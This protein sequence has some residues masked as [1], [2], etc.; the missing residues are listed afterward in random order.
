M[1]NLHPNSTQ[2]P[3][4]ILDQW[5]PHLS[6]SELRVVLYVCRRTYGFGKLEDRI[7]LKQMSEGIKRKDGSVLDQGAGLS[8]SA[9]AEACKSLEQKRVL[10][11]SQQSAEGKGDTATAY[12]LNL[13]RRPGGGGREG[14]QKSDTGC[15]ETGHAPVQNLDTQNT[16]VQNTVDNS[17]PIVP[18]KG[19]APKRK[20]GK[21]S[22]DY[23]SM[24]DAFIDA[25]PLGGKLAVLI[26]LAASENITNTIT[27]SRQWTEFCEGLKGLRES[28]LTDEQIRHGLTGAIKNQAP[29][30]N[31]VKT[32]AVKLRAVPSSSESGSG[33]TN[34][35]GVSESERNEQAGRNTKGY[36]DIFSVSG[37]SDEPAEP[38]DKDALLAQMRGEQVPRKGAA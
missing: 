3:N 20:K 18:S 28:G 1:S 29:N 25:D 4:V 19:D 31:Y 37:G 12:S 11:R 33:V 8:K 34:T 16:E 17:T 15:P 7:S 5:L 35:Y 27:W 9:A 10:N 23:A 24:V 22:R 13:D 14:V 32:C 38:F 6:G 30:M 2:I 36:E 21:S 26:D